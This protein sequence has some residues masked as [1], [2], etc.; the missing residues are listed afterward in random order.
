MTELLIG[1]IIG[2]CLT[3]YAIRHYRRRFGKVADAVRWIIG[4]AKE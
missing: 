4:V 1:I 2:V 3:V